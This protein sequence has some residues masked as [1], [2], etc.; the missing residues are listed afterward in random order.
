MSVNESIF[1]PESP[2]PPRLRHES[3][4]PRLRKES[5]P[6]RLRDSEII[7]PNSVGKEDWNQGHEG[8]TDF[9][10]DYFDQYDD[11]RPDEEEDD[12]EEEH[13]WMSQH[14]NSFD[15]DIED[16]LFCNGTLLERIQCANYG[17][18]P[19]DPLFE[20]SSHSAKDFCRYMT[21]IKHSTGKFIHN[22]I[23]HFFIN[24]SLIKLLCI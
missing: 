11:E 15:K 4:P 12:E 18:S 24:S 9:E 23:N 1:V 3:P 21:A 2:S 13:E 17:V 7:I 5:P 22:D 8:C 6:P 10:D 20:G 14:S 16:D 19:S